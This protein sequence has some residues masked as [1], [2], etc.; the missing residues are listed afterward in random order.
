MVVWIRSL[1]VFA[2]ILLAFQSAHAV[3][4]MANMPIRHFTNGLNNWPAKRAMLF[5]RRWSGA[6]GPRLGIT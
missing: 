5:G 2:A 1:A 6:L 4:A 3:I